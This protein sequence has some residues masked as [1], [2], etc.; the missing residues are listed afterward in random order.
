MA[1]TCAF[2]TKNRGFGST[3]KTISPYG[4][5]S[6]KF[7]GIIGNGQKY[8]RAFCE[9]GRLLDPRQ[10]TKEVA[11]EDLRFATGS[12]KFFRIFGN[13]QKAIARFLRNSEVI[14]RRTSFAQDLRCAPACALFAIH[15]IRLGNTNG[16]QGIVLIL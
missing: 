6:K 11:S 14:L 16:G 10:K 9:L 2:L 13:T 1:Q 8:L 4:I 5:R 12:K 7:F 3:Q 15:S